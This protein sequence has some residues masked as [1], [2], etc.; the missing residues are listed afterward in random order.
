M[1]SEGKML[2]N[3]TPGVIC[4]CHWFC[5]AKKLFAFSSI[6]LNLFVK[7]FV[8]SGLYIYATIFILNLSV[9]T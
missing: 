4:N 1:Y 7:H 2:V 6:S 8:C 9:Q 3:F 5:M